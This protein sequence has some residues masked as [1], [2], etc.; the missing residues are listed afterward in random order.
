MYTVLITR[1]AQRA[2]EKVPQNIDAHIRAALDALGDHPRPVGST[3]L[4]GSKLWRIRVG[5]YR[6][7][8]AIDDEQRVVTVL[9]IGHRR[10]VYR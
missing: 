8:Y 5:A 7:I 3:K 2:L 4:S 1:T 6:V 9:K 10:D